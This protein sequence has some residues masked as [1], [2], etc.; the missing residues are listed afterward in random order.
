MV[1]EC[2]QLPLIFNVETYSNRLMDHCNLVG[3]KEDGWLELYKCSVCDQ[4]WQVDVTDKLQIN[5]AVKIDN[6]A[7]WQNF[8]DK[9]IRMQY[10]VDSRG[11][12]SDEECVVAGCKN[13]ALKSLVYCTK[14]AYEN[15]GLRE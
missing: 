9:A 14:H 6:P 4:Y 1:C 2:N 7:N 3:Q 13:K 15:A 5:C 11:G 12:F 8:D 10:L